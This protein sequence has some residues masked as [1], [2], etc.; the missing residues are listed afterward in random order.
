MSTW[1]L[2]LYN[3]VPPP[4]RSILASLHGYYLRWWRYDAG[5]DALIGHALERDLW[6]PEQWRRWQSERLSYL[7][8]RAATRVPFYRDHWQQRRQ[9]GDRASWSYLQNWPIL[10]KEAVRRNPNAF[11][12]DDRKISSLYHLHTSGTT[13]KP[14]ELWRGRETSRN[15]Y[16]LFEA[17]T[18]GWQGIAREQRW[19]IFG[20]Q[21]VA[22]FAQRR[23]PFWVWNTA[24]NQL[25]MSSYH[26]SPEFSDAYL[27]ALAKYKVRYLVGYT[28]ALFALAQSVVRS[29]RPRTPMEAV[30]TNAEPLFEY[31]RETISN[32]FACAVRETYG[33]TELVAAASECRHGCLHLWPE[34]GV[35]ETLDGDGNEVRGRSSDLICTGLINDDMPLIRYRV[36]DR[37]TLPEAEK[38]CDCGRGLPQIESIDGRADEVVITRD[39]RRVGRLDPVFKGGLPL[40]EAQIVQQTVEKIVVRFVPAED[41]TPAAGQLIISRLR[42]RVGPVDVKLEAVR[43]IPRGANGKFRAVVSLVSSSELESCPVSETGSNQA[44]SF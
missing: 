37:G 44:R 26:L 8:H 42:E 33:M 43:R 27:M 23:P 11:I 16:A 34:A 24:L 25:Y 19:A 12:A 13:G 38:A 3:R 10:E 36:G 28:S 4:A 9:R 5:T 15:W 18:R 40:I 39:G 32:A 41:Y 29:G 31:Q 6:S 35:V 22:P 17:R 20:G 30:I 2:K 21:L 7:L 14:I 1:A